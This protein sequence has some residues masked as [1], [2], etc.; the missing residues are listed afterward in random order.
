MR[1]VL[2]LLGRQKMMAE[3]IVI[4]VVLGGWLA[5]Q[6]WILPYFGVQT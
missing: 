4:G 3:L 2:I 5:L 1:Q 6:I